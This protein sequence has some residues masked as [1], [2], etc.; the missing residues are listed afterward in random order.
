[1]IGNKFGGIMITMFVVIPLIVI[2][3]EILSWINPL[4]KKFSK[5][6]RA[7][8]KGRQL[9]EIIESNQMPSP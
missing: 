3:H 6:S 2:I 4:I 1:M 9:G 8:A 7:E 5:I